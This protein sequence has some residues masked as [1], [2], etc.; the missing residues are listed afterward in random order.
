LSCLSI[1]RKNQL[2]IFI[3]IFDLQNKKR[4]IQLKIPYIWSNYSN[5]YNHYH[6]ERR[7][8]LNRFLIKVY[9]LLHSMVNTGTDWTRR[10]KKWEVFQM[11]IIE[12][13]WLNARK[14]YW[15]T[16]DGHKSLSLN[17]D[18]LTI[19]IIIFNL[20]RK[21]L[22]LFTNSSHLFIIPINQ[23]KTRRRKLQYI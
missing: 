7:R 1:C 10:R 20:N 23:M 22:P 14:T 12:E 2:F 18:L 6:N 17:Y 16:S 3:R 8:L 11:Q 5:Q 9:I 21:A 4:N 19:I 13:I 15:S